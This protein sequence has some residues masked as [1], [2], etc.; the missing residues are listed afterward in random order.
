MACSVAGSVKN[1]AQGGIPGNF[2]I[3]FTADFVFNG[4]N[5][6]CTEIKDQLLC[7]IVIGSKLRETAEAIQAIFE[8]AGCCAVGK[9]FIPSAD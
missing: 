7:G 2:D 1:P 5:A 8:I 6:D 3:G 4:F 9:K